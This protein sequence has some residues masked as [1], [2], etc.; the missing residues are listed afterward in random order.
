MLERDDNYPPAEQLHRELDAMSAA[1]SAGRG[2]RVAEAA[3][4]A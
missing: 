3:S 4:V 2:R 1:V